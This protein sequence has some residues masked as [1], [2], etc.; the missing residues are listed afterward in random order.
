M[1]CSLAV[2]VFTSAITPFML[3]SFDPIAH[4]IISLRVEF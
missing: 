1:N 2:G 4:A 3:Q